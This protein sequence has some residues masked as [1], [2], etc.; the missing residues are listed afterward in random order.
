[1]RYPLIVLDSMEDL[2]NLKQR[3]QKSSSKELLRMVKVDFAD[4]RPEVLDWAWQE[5]KSRGYSDA[6]LRAIN[7]GVPKKKDLL[8]DP[9]LAGIGFLVFIA[10]TAVITFSLFAPIIY[11]SVIAYGLPASVFIATG[12]CVWAALVRKGSERATAFGISFASPVLLLL[13]AQST[14]TPKYVGLI[15]VEFSCFWL[16][17][18]LATLRWNKDRSGLTS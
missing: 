10:A 15:I 11:Y 7:L 8:A 2:K 5:L 6:D 9:Q 14:A 3:L 18:K 12:Y 1:V 17:L 13:T 16:L 4:Y